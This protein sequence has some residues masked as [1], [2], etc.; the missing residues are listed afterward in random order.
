MGVE[1]TLS[2]FSGFMCGGGGI[3]GDGLSNEL[4]DGNK[5]E[6]DISLETRTSGC[7]RDD[8]LAKWCSPHSDFTRRLG[9]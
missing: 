5:M 1:R 3:L 8:C 9:A 6:G 2:T 4:R 7:P